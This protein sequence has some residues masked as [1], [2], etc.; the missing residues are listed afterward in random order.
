MQANREP[1]PDFECFVQARAASLFRTA[2][3]LSCQDR[4]EA[5]DLLQVCLE[6][7]YR[8]WHRIAIQGVEPERYA[9]RILVNAAL[10]RRRWLRRRPE[11]PLS[12]AGAGLSVPDQVGKVAERDALVRALGTLPARQRSALVLRYFDDLDDSEIAAAL[13]CSPGTV[14]S[15]LSRGLARLRQVMGEDAAERKEG[16]RQ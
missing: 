16:A 15:H 13:G 3:A 7:V 8:H 10:D 12:A 14:R 2:L 4:A 6:R 11:W 5:E 9:R 1:R